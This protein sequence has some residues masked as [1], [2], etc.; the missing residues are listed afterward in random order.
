MYVT[1][2]R[3]QARVARIG[4][5]PLQEL[6]DQIYEAAVRPEAWSRVLDDIVQRLQAK[7]A[8]IEAYD[9]ARSE[10]DIVC[11]PID[12]AFA[13]LY[14]NYWATRNFLWEGSNRLAVGRTFS[15]DTFISTDDRRTNRF[16]RE[17]FSPQGLDIALGANLLK[18][19]P[20]TVIFTVFRPKSREGFA[21]TDVA[22]FK[23][24]LPHLARATNIRRQLAVRDAAVLD[25]QAALQGLQ[26]PA[27]IVTEELV[28]LF[29]NVAAERL[30]TGK[31]LRMSRSG[32]IVTD[33]SQTTAKFQA[34][35]RSVYCEGIEPGSGRLSI[36]RRHGRPLTLSLTRLHPCASPF[37]AR[38][39]LALVDDPEAGPTVAS[40]PGL[41]KAH[42]RL[43]D[44]ESRIA[45]AVGTGMPL[46]AVADQHAIT[47][48]TVRVHLS[49][50]FGKMN[51][52]SQSELAIL[53][54]R[55]GLA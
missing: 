47:Y 28:I 40:G 45:I 30:F 24:M 55:S 3:L 41:L 27:M 15:F 26:R 8:C 35:A 16:F 1:S 53:V 43:T 54:A 17:W 25:L 31:G 42:Y 44:A 13:E 48:A 21:A 7:D 32:Q 49:R 29:A 33:D 4:D 46:R 9:S 10:S 51:V 5:R 36:P 22:S 6:V 20:L 19:G 11:H 50:I 12:P 2:N 37:C 18:D 39:I 38:T 52:S 14:E 34:S 23:A